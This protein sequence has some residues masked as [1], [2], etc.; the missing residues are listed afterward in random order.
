MIEFD[1]INFTRLDFECSYLHLTMDD[2][3]QLS[4]SYPV[5]H[6]W[7]EPDLT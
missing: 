5:D 3:E 4:Q 7:L 6:D 2:G 1:L